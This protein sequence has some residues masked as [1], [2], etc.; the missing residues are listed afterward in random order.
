MLNFQEVKNLWRKNMYNNKLGAILIATLIVLIGG[1][2]GGGGSSTPSIPPVVVD[3]NLSVPFQTAMAN[4]INNG[5]NKSYTLSGAVTGSGTWAIGPATA[6]TITSGSLNGTSVLQSTLVA[7]GTDSTTGTYLYS[8]SNYTLLKESFTSRNIYFS[9]Y[10]NPATVKAGNTGTLGSGSDNTV[11]P[12][13][14]ITSVYSV[15]SNAANSLLVTITDTWAVGG[16]VLAPSPDTI[17]K[18][19]VY[20]I[21]TSGNITLVSETETSYSLGSVVSTVNFTFS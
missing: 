16:L 1:C 9:A 13:S 8:P 10:T 4:L 14:T 6:V 3:P 19:T 20:N 18:K 7:T 21:D 11:F 15:A 17:V 2:G 12:A 5:V